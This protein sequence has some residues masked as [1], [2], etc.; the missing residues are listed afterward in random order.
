M[1]RLFLQDLKA[2]HFLFLGDREFA[3]P[4]VAEWTLEFLIVNKMKILSCFPT[5]VP[6]VRY[7]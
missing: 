5:L 3:D 1:V 6:Q 2:A 4:I 7:T